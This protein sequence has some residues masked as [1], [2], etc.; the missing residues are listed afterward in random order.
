ME[1]P[2]RKQSLVTLAQQVGVKLVDIAALL[3]ADIALPWIRVAVTTL[4][5]EVQCRIRECYGA[6]RAN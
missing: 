4:V 1:R 6:K 5:Q 2:P 3:S